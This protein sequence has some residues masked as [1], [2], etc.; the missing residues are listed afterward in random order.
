MAGDPSSRGQWSLLLLA[1]ALA[2]YAAWQAAP[3][4]RRMDQLDRERLETT[5]RLQRDIET[6][7]DQLTRARLIASAPSAAPSAKPNAAGREP[8]PPT[9]T[10]GA[11]ASAPS[12]SSASSVSPPP[13]G[14][15]RVEME[16]FFDR[17]LLSEDARI[18]T[19]LVSSLP[20]A[21]IALR[22]KHSIAFIIAKGIQIEKQLS[23]APDTPPEVLAALRE[24]VQR[25]KA[26]QR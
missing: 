18:A 12:S 23:S 20:P 10:I 14:L 26:T 22:L 2:G 16:T 11:T 15:T 8:A 25:A 9:P 3:L 7:R 24:A 4:S 21:E 17:R 1:V 6:L 5:D 13:G 19:L